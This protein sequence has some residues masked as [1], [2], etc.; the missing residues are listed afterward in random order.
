MDDRAS[1]RRKLPTADAPSIEAST[2]GEVGTGFLEQ[3]KQAVD[4][5]GRNI[6]TNFLELP[7]KKLF[8][9]YYKEIT[10]P[11]A[12]DIIE[13]K[14][15]RKKYPDISAF[16]SDVKLMVA[17]AKSYN[18]TNSEIFN[19]AERIR[20]M[21]SSYLGKG[22]GRFPKAPET[23]T[24][25][26]ALAD[27]EGEENPAAA[28]EEFE[29]ESAE[30]RKRKRSRAE[31]PVS[32]TPV[33]GLQVDGK[34]GEKYEGTSFQQAQ[35][36]II[37][38]LIDLKDKGG[39]EV[40]YPFHNLPPR[41]LKDYYAL[42]KKPVSLNG[43]MKRVKGVRGK[44]DITGVTEFKTWHAFE[45]EVSFLWRNAREY[46]E[47]GSEIS[48]LAGELEKYFKDRITEAKRVVSE[49]G[50]RLK[51]NMP[52]PKSPEPSR[53]RVKLHI[54]APKASPAP[55]S[56]S[57]ETPA[58]KE[59]VPAEAVPDA[60][61]PGKEENQSQPST[62]PRTSPARDQTTPQPSAKDTTGVSRSGSVSTGISAVGKASQ[63]D[64]QKAVTTAS[65]APSAAAV[66]S[67]PQAGRSP[68]LGAIRVSST[69]PEK[70]SEMRRESHESIKATQSPRLD[71]SSM[72]PPSG[73]TPRLA[74]GSPNPP[75]SQAPPVHI[76]P[77]PPPAPPSGMS[78]LRPP[79]KDAS[80]ALISNLS[81]STHPGLRLPRPFQLNIPP[82]DS[83]SQQSITINLAPMHYMLQIAPIIA[84]SLN[85]RP[86]KVFV[87]VNY[88]R[89]NPVPHAS[90]TTDTKRPWYEAKLVPGINRIEVEIIAG[91]TRGI[92][93]PSTA[94]DIELEKI[95]V[96][97]N[98]MKA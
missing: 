48:N 97:A 11:I 45:D 66:K 91:P 70:A 47:D 85:T 80:D 74:D 49:P 88:Q 72:P 42:I 94:Q 22:V 53:P 37:T 51:L 29:P 32:P 15:A 25:E 8:P 87:T 71:S 63:G 54:G 28:G 79:G 76:P 73:S 35:E 95:T 17:N 21:L 31:R 83:L 38:E 58:R 9:D 6:A 27:A 65:P 90:G 26:T 96:F 19:D 41:A 7:E 59:S 10:T 62:H 1:K 64:T 77:P 52:A 39:E 43:I 16:E 40:S 50:P 89:L 2:A 46:N 33:N 34:D 36:M 5:R 12:I 82:S 67:E 68:S 44:K 61:S 98:L 75:Q 14:L 24:S 84:P 92:P 81:I 20:K 13:A 18:E 57:R 78:M 4:K 55:S 23:I 86:S 69:G 60:G 3:L 93:K 30:S 56:I